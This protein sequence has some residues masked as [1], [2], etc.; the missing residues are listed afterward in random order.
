[1]RFNNFRN[2]IA[3]NSFDYKFLEIS[4]FPGCFY[5]MIN[6]NIISSFYTLT[7]IIRLKK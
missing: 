7:E 4:C 5:L 6:D 3:I 1:M 2:P